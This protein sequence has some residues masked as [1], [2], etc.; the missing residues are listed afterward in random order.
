[1]Q[2]IPICVGPICV[3]GLTVRIK[4]I[5]T[6]LGHSEQFFVACVPFYVKAASV[7]VFGG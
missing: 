2:D 3:R 5:L 6:G 7:V 1:M 4:E